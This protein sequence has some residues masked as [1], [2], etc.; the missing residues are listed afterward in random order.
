M[1]WRT[2]GSESI[3]MMDSMSCGTRGRRRRRGVSIN[4]IL[5]NY[6]IEDKHAIGSSRS[7]RQ[8]VAL[9]AGQR[10]GLGPKAAIRAAS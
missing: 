5:V 9:G 6:R 7:T 3:A 4:A 1:N 2:S 8:A 10:S